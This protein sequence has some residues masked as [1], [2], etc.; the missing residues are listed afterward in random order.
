MVAAPVTWSGNAEDGTYKA[1]EAEKTDVVT[2][3]VGGVSREVHVVVEKPQ[4]KREFV[5][6]KHGDLNTSKGY[7][8]DASG[9]K[10]CLMGTSLFWSC[11]APLWWSKE[12]IDYLVDKYN[13]QVIRLPAAIA[14][15]GSDAQTSCK[16]EPYVDT[17]NKDC[18]YWRPE[19]TRRLVDEVV[20]AAIE[21]DIYV[22]IDFHEH[23]AQDW[24]AL[25]Q[26]FF[27]YFAKKWGK[28]PNVM[29]EIF[30]EPVD[31]N[32]TVVNYAKQIIPTIR[33]IDPDN[34]IIVGSAQF[35]RDPDGVTEAGR[36]QTNIAYTW[37]GY[38]QY[39]H[40]EDWRTEKAQAW[41]TSIPVV[42]TEWGLNASGD[43]GGLLDTFKTKG[44]IHCFW[45]MSNTGGEDVKWSV[46]KTGCFKKAGWTDEEMNKNGAFMLAQAKGWLKYR[47]T[48]RNG[49]GLSMTVCPDKE[50]SLSEKETVL[51]GSA[52]GGTENY[53]YTWTQVKGPNQATIAS[54]HAAET[55]VSGL[56]VGMY[57]FMLGVSDGEEELFDFVSIYPEGSMTGVPA[58]SSRP[59]FEVYPNPVKDG[60]ITIVV[61]Q[62]SVVSIFDVMG[63]LVS[64]TVAVPNMGNNV[65]L[66]GE[67]VYFVKS[68]CSVRKIIVL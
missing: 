17:W 45:S 15:C 20:K 2:V 62:K 10:V 52:S 14:P 31:D 9:N 33:A 1:G 25:A 41:N 54:P 50:F 46:L 47:P 8:G 35:S 63:R 34:I 22:I 16:R 30:N 68:G 18:Y 43:D 7:V 32:G 65:T 5:V 37:H 40:Q 56:I 60:V 55:K 42:V 39:G 66:S 61:S 21:N 48:D 59:D 11:S 44:V 57:T 38:T 28:Y 13:I 4:K 67:G 29:Y 64:T 24:T 26:E 49:V 19:Y 12:T 23:K 36:G 6:S 27:A 53:T 3:T 51:T 58:V